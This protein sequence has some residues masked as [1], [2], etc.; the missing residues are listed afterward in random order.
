MQT[1]V[2]TETSKDRLQVAAVEGTKSSASAVPADAADDYF[3]LPICTA[4]AAVNSC[5]ILP[6]W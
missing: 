6:F 5:Q 2:I 1:I 4:Q 3:P